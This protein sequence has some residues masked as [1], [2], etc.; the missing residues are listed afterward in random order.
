MTGRQVRLL[1]N[2]TRDGR[3]GAA[4]F[5]PPTQESGMVKTMSEQKQVHVRAYERI[6]FGRK[7]HV[8]EHWRSWPGQLSFD[9]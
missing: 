6:R 1:A 8:C 3:V 5:S 9:F 2:G 7:E 4:G